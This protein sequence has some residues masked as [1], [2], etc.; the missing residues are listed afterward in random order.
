LRAEG[1]ESLLAGHIKLAYSRPFAW[2]SH[3]CVLWCAEWVRLATGADH[4]EKYRGAYHTA[5]GAKALLRK[6]RLASPEAV[7]DRFLRAKPVMLARRGDVVLHPQ[8]VLGICHGHHSH[9]LTADGVLAV[10]TLSCPK[11]WGVD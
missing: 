6:K 1:W 9:F 10:P 5:A 4:A 11:A 3:D 2:G 7:A 8:G